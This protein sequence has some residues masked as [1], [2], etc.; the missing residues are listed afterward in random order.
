MTQRKLTSLLMILGLLVS[1]FHP[2]AHA[3]AATHH[4]AVPHGHE[5]G[6][7][8]QQGQQSKGLF[9]DLQLV[10]PTSVVLES[11]RVA[12]AP[13]ET[14]DDQFAVAHC[15]VC[16]VFSHIMAV[17]SMAKSMTHALSRGPFWQSENMTTT[18]PFLPDRPPRTIL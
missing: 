14:Q 15:E 16:H 4:D 9:S 18:E 3:E 5:R 2:L 6:N 13:I 8:R 7:L 11:T 1:L 10:A 17:E 12:A